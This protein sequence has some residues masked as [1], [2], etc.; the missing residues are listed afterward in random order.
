[1]SLAITHV[2]IIIMTICLMGCNKTTANLDHKSPS[3]LPLCW[4]PRYSAVLVHA[5][6][7]Q[8]QGSCNMVKPI[9]FIH[10]FIE[11][12]IHSLVVACLLSAKHGRCKRSL[13]SETWGT[14]NRMCQ[15]WIQYS[16]GARATAN[17]AW[18]RT[19]CRD[20]SVSSGNEWR[21]HSSRLKAIC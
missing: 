19:V 20:T 7:G 12:S 6:A 5:K 10:S 4:A 1:M 17:P 21:R 2:L 3:P 13:S 15:G 16:P 18:S 8:S 14:I 11:V 9:L